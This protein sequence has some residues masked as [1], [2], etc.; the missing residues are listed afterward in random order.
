[1][2]PSGVEKAE[3]KE[4]NKSEKTLRVVLASMGVLIVGVVIAIVVVV[5]TR[6]VNNDDNEGDSSSVS[7]VE[8]DP[9]YVEANKIYN[10]TLSE[11]VDVI[12]D[13]PQEREKLVIDTYKSYIAKVD[14]ELARA[15]LN[16]ER[17]CVEMNY[18]FNRERGAEIKAEALE[19]DAILQDINSAGL[20]LNV[21]SQY[22]DEELYEKY[23]QILVERGGI[24]PGMEPEG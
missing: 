18:D 3:K 16:A 8:E 14:N 2:K 13:V 12:E 22:D 7:P 21:A 9:A 4:R 19:I 11:I 5:S 23:K 10:K 15:M 6:K 1:M 17:L 20:I 24:E